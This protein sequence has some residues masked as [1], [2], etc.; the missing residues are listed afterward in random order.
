MNS[1][2]IGINFR[3]VWS[4]RLILVTQIIIAVNFASPLL[5]QLVPLSIPSW[6]VGHR[7]LLPPVAPE[8][9]A[10]MREVMSKQKVNNDTPQT[11]GVPSQQQ[12]ALTKLVLEL[13]DQAGKG[14][15]WLYAEDP[16]PDSASYPAHDFGLSRV[17]FLREIAFDHELCVTWVIPLL[18]LRMAWVNDK[19]HAGKL[20]DS[21]FYSTELGAM[22]GCITH[23][24]NPTDLEEILQLREEIR[25]STSQIAK[26]LNPISDE[27]KKNMLTEQ[28][29]AD[30]MYGFK[31]YHEQFRNAEKHLGKVERKN[32]EVIW[33]ERNMAAAENSAKAKVKIPN[34]QP[35]MED[36]SDSVINTWL[37]YVAVI[38]IVM[39]LVGVVWLIRNKSFKN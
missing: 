18:K 26:H 10:L 30:E 8:A 25:L 9:V 5:A 4:S 1:K 22:L 24:G 37:Y 38:V 32:A 17:E 34:A 11:D 39:L 31:P 2:T 23:H 3:F 19:L 14:I 20:D 35:R 28:K 6:M 16:L 27:D 15:V 12:L 33:K 13:G 7:D 21:Q 36:H 29:V